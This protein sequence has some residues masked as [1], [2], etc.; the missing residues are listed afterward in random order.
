TDYGLASKASRFFSSPGCGWMEG[1]VSASFFRHGE[2]AAAG[3]VSHYPGRQPSS[4]CKATTAVSSSG[5]DRPGMPPVC[6]STTPPA[7][8]LGKVNPSKAFCQRFGHGQRTANA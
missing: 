8:A 1:D 5:A 2:S 7:V 4:W 3:A 6:D